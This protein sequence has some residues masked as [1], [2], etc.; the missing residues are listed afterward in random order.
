MCAITKRKW[1]R[2][3][4]TLPG[5]LRRRRQF[6]APP[7]SAGVPPASSPSVSLG[8]CPGGE[9][10]LELA[11]VDGHTCLAWCQRPA[12]RGMVVRRIGEW[13]LCSCAIAFFRR[14]DAD[15]TLNTYGRL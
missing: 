1:V 9:T 6:W 2:R 14:Q 15:S 5:S 7:C 8:E 4:L 13:L 3:S 12:G 10:P 11:A